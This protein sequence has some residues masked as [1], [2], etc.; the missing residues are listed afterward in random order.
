MSG[1]FV[2]WGQFRL[3][4]SLCAFLGHFK[5][6]NHLIG[7]SKCWLS[8]FFLLLF[9]YHMKTVFYWLFFLLLSLEVYQYWWWLLVLLCIAVIVVAFTH[10]CV[11]DPSNTLY[12]T[13]YSFMFFTSKKSSFISYM[14]K[15]ILSYTNVHFFLVR[16]NLFVR[17]NQTH[18]MISTDIC[19]Q[20]T[21]TAEIYYLNISTSKYSTLH[22]I[23]SPEPKAHLVSL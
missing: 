14:T 21:T 11:R 23:S 18:V 2:L 17:G 15:H 12:R 8:C 6:C 22:I 3:R 1:D 13:I 20:A 5:H 10:A 9:T 4:I 7:G 16:V 19:S